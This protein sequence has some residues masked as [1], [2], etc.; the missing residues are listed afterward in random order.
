MIKTTSK[1][2]IFTVLA[3]LCLLFACIFPTLNKVTAKADEGQT[4][5]V[6]SVSDIGMGYIGEAKEYSGLDKDYRIN[7]SENNSLQSF[8]FKFYYKPS[9]LVNSDAIDVRIGFEDNWNSKVR[10]VLSAD[11]KNLNLMVGNEVKQASENVFTDSQKEYFV[12][13]KV[14]RVENGQSSIVANVDDNEKINQ[15]IAD[16]GAYDD[17]N[18]RIHFY[19]A[20]KNVWTIRDYRELDSVYDEVTLHDLYMTTT[21]LQ[22][23]ELILPVGTGQFGCWNSTNVNSDVVFKFYYN[24]GNDVSKDDPF[25]IR[26]KTTTSDHMWLGISI[27]LNHF[28]T[29]NLTIDKE[30]DGDKGAVTVGNVFT[31]ANHEYFVEIGA[32]GIERD[33][34]SGYIYVKVDGKLAIATTYDKSVYSGNWLSFWQTNN[35]RDRVINAAETV[36]IYNENDEIIDKYY[37]PYKSVIEIPPYEPQAKS[38]DKYYNDY[39]YKYWSANEKDEFDFENTTVKKDIALKPYYLGKNAKE[40]E[41]TF[42]GYNSEQKVKYSKDVSFTGPSVPEKPHYRGQWE[43]YELNF[44][45]GQEVNAEYHAILYKVLVK[46]TFDRKESQVF[47]FS[48]DDTQDEINSVLKT[49]QGLNTDKSLYKWDIEPVELKLGQDYVFTLSKNDTSSKTSGCSGNITSGAGLFA[50]IVLSIVAFAVYSTN[51]KNKR[52]G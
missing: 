20:T 31:Q 48:A 39:E 5:D 10:F 9:G 19:T 22:K 41:V 17:T 2:N 32:V 15:T 47:Y 28:D 16:I 4:V 40:Y 26:M 45:E 34:E 36:E 51:K 7:F 14:I 12:E 1:R 11:G 50:P 24:T 25:Y 44:E 23:E 43:D 52:R 42:K 38:A 13:F 35:V 29:C 21:R 3:V 18:N 27:K 6:F 30:A 37:V 49:V 8:I 33:L 46:F